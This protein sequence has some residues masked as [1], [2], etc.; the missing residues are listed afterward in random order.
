MISSI[1]KWISMIF[2]IWNEAW[3]ILKFYIFFEVNLLYYV[4]NKSRKFLMLVKKLN[5]KVIKLFRNLPHEFSYIFQ[6]RFKIIV[7]KRCFG[8]LR[9][10][11]NLE[12][13]VTAKIHQF[14]TVSYPKM[15]Y[16]TGGC[17]KNMYMFCS[18]WYMYGTDFLIM[19]TWKLINT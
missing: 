9:T 19:M 12:I 13:H 1:L 11:S 8:H 15:S 5:K 18:W 16:Y 6:K 3:I 7:W 10:L 17:F 14:E 2:S 4:K